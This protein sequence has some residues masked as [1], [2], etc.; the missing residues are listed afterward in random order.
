L[1]AAHGGFITRAA[2]AGKI[3]PHVFFRM[4]AQERGGE[5]YPRPIGSFKRAW[6]L[7]CH[8]AGVPGKKLRDLRR[9]A[10]R[11][12]D[13][14]GVSR[15]VPMKMVGHRTE[16]IYNRYNITIDGDLRDAARKLDAAAVSSASANQSGC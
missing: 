11:D 3:E 1:F 2:K 14:A 8:S 4:V 15:T 13:R 10:V 12:L 7:A 9:T 16:S 5:K 6:R